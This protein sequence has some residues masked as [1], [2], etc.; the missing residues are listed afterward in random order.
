MSFQNASLKIELTLSI[1]DL[2][3]FHKAHPTHI[4]AAPPVYLLYYAHRPESFFFVI[5]G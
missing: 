1:F 5:I 2:L 4:F 3:I